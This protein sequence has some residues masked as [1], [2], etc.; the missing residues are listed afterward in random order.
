[1]KRA[2]FLILFSLLAAAFSAGAQENRG[3]T[4]PTS[5]TFGLSES[6]QAFVA[7]MQHRMDSIRKHRPTVAL[8]LSGGG[9]KGAATIGVLQYLKKYDFPIDIVAGTSIGGLIGGLYA[10]GYT[11]DAIESMVRGMDWDMA[12]SDKVDKSYVPY[13]RI[14]YKEK[15]LLSIPFYY[16]EEDYRRYITGDAS[17]SNG[18]PQQFDLGATKEIKN[19]FMGSLPSGFVYGQNV[20]QVFTSRSVGYSDS[21]DFS[22]LPIPFICVAT[23]MVSSKAKIWHSGS[24]NTA[25]RSTMSIPGLFVP[26]RTEGMILVDGGMRNNYPTNLVK[27]L[28]ADIIIGVDLSGANPSAEKIQNLGDILMQSMDLFSNDAREYNLPLLDVS[29]HPDLTGYNMLSFNSEAIDVMYWKGFKAA[30]EKTPQLDSIRR[31]LGKSHFSLQAPPATDIG[32]TSVVIEGIDIVG[33]PEKE[34]QYILSRMFIKPGTIV[35]KRVIEEDVAKIFGRGAYDYVNYELRGSSEPYRLRIICK[36]GPMHQFGLGVRMDSRDLVSILLNVGLNTNAMSG[37]SLDF[38]SRISTNPYAELRYSYN[39]P[40]FATFNAKAFVRYTNS[41]RFLSGTDRFNISFIEGTQELFMSNMRWTAM[42]VKI[43]L[44]NQFYKVINVLSNASDGDYDYPL[45]FKDYPGAFITG[46]VETLDN[47]YFPT[48]GVSAGF[49]ADLMTRALY[50]GEPL[51]FGAA[52]ADF[53]VPVSFGRFSLIPQGSVRFLLGEDIPIQYANVLGGD[54]SGQYVDQQIPFIGL[55]NC[56][57]RR[58]CLAVARLDARVRLW[59]N[60][61]VSLIGNTAYDFVNF[62]GIG[63]G[64]LVGGAGLS[65]AYNSVFGPM[66]LQLHWS[67]LTRSVGA[68]LS[69]GYNF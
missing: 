12:L 42:D 14:R 19:N 1:M 35:N 15:Y 56:A 31:V 6:D 10:M 9:A 38:T 18:L 65:Y 69:L 50:P 25:L 40:I 21:L 45:D 55:S 51:F 20:N 43:G 59:Q 53:T 5:S 39:A 26:V 60:H 68:Y 34:A 30:A 47:G 46:R 8:V 28:G 44:Q 16:R 64:Q 41:S 49:R 57:F 29:I 33:V 58:N 66:K 24:I 13:S 2:F 27:K 23:D 37:H 36:R 22:K 32:Q 7:K 17:L 3:V 48:K 4:E 52:S 11:P 62:E 61:Y 54:I 67:S 63:D